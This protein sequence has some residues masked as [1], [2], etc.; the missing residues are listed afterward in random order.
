MFQAFYEHFY[1]SFSLLAKCKLSM[2][3]F[4]YWIHL[5]VQDFPYPM[6]ALSIDCLVALNIVLKPLETKMQQIFCIDWFLIAAMNL[7]QCL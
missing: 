4:P 5:L 1:M 3:V 6:L 2:P 7:N